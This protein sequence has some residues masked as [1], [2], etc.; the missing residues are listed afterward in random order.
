MALTVFE[1]NMM[2]RL[3]NAQERQAEALE[4]IVNHLS[5]IVEVLNKDKVTLKSD[6]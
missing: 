2:K 3:I 1:E 4:R 6:T 5:T